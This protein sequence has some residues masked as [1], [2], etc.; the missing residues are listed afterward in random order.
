[1]SGLPVLVKGIMSP[2]AAE[3]AVKAGA[4]GIWVSNHG[5][6]QLDGAPAAFDMLPLIAEAVN[7]RVPIVFDSGIRRGTHVF[8]ALASGA[9][10]VAIGRPALYGLIL[11]G[12]DGVNDF[13]Q[14]LNKELTIAMTLA[15]TQNSDEGKKNN[16]F[17]PEK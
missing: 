15:G 5:G 1:M 16:L 10:I 7:G 2:A 6:R 4:D 9:D 14:Q 11:G 12:S 13:F 17:D 3:S 8:K